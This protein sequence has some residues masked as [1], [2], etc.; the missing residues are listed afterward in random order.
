[1][2]KGNRR[3]GIGYRKLGVTGGR[4][5]ACVC[6]G[7]GY[8]VVSDVVAGKQGLAQ[9]YLC[10]AAVVGTVVVNGGRSYGCLPLR[11]KL[12]RGILTLGNRR[13]CIG[14]GNGGAATAGIATSIGSKQGY[15]ILSYL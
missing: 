5:A 4:I 8:G 12:Y 3:Y 10:N 7:K 1:L 2:A 14:N 15:G 6:Y 13:R 9:V 11:I